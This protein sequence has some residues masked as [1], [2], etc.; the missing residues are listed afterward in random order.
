MRSKNATL[1]ERFNELGFE[2]ESEYTK[3][4]IDP[5]QLITSIPLKHIKIITH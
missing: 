3:Y 5:S 1:V 2:I 4:K